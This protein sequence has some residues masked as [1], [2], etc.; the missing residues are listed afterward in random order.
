VDAGSVEVKL[1]DD[2]EVVQQTRD[3]RL[4]GQRGPPDSRQGF[5]R[6]GGSD[7]VL[8]HRLHIDDGILAA[9]RQAA[10]EARGGGDTSYGIDAQ[11]HQRPIYRRYRA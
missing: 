9:P 8:N 2:P 10:V 1:Y 4:R 6:R 3:E 7:A 11:H 5:S